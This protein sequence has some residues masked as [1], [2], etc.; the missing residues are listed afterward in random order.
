MGNVVG[1]IVGTVAGGL[2][3]RS[4][5]KKADRAN[6]AVA[7]AQAQQ[8]ALAQEQWDRYKNLYSP[9]ETQIVRQAQEGTSP[10]QYDRAAAEASATVGAQFG[11][12][13]DRLGRTPGLDPSSAAYQHGMIGLDIAQAAADATAQNAARQSVTDDGWNKQM[14]ALSLGKGLPANAMSGLNSA[15]S[16]AATM[17]SHANS[18]ASQNAQGFGQLGQ[19]IG[20]MVG[21]FTNNGNAGGSWLG[22][23]FSGS[24]N[25]NGGT[26]LKY[27]ASGWGGFG[28]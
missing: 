23:A 4:S 27:D 20:N 5:Q 13:R 21:S 17:A 3:G 16:T 11:K 10:A 15:A 8:A 19:A 22:G 26:G 25:G 7:E 14:A 2:F 6:Q 18:A 9:L 12:A 24:K 28:L 1:G